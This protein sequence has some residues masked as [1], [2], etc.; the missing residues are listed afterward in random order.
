MADQVVRIALAG[1][2]DPTLRCSRCSRHDAT[3]LQLHG[4][5][6][7]AL[8]VE[9]HP[10][11]SRMFADRPQEKIPIDAVKVAPYIDVQHPVVPPA[12]LAGLPDGVDRRSAW[13][14]PIRIPVEDRLQDGF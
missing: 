3:V 10:G 11:A 14:V 6:Q 7:P 1:T 8:D 5:L 4:R 12:A 9:K 13:S 2:D